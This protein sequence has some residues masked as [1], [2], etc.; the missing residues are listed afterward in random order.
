MAYAALAEQYQQQVMDK[1]PLSSLLPRATLDALPPGSDVSGL[2]ESCGLLSA[3]QLEIT[4]LDATE[5]LARIATKEFSSVEVVTAF[6]IRTA[7]AHQVTCCLTDFFIDEAIAAAQELDAYLAR[8]GKTR[9]PLHGLPISAKDQVELIGK[10]TSLGFT[11]LH[12]TAKPAT[13]N[14]QLAQILIDAGAVFFNHTTLPQSIMHLECNSFLWGR[15]LLPFN[16]SLSA[17]GSS[18]GEGAVLGMRGAPLGLG[19]DI[20]G[21][22]RS[23]AANNG[24]YGLRPTASRVPN[25]GVRTYVPGRDSILGI[26]GPLCHSA[27]DIELFMSVVLSS[28]AKPWRRD[29]SLLEMPWRVGRMGGWQEGGR[30]LRVGVMWHDGEV[31]PVRG[32]ERALKGA[33]EKLRKSGEVEVVDFE[34]WKTRE[35]WDLIRQLYFPDGGRRIHQLTD[36]SEVEEPLD[37]LTQWLLAEAGPPVRE[38]SIHELWEL[39]TRREAYRKGYQ[40]HWFSQAIDVL[41]CPV[42]PYPAPPH[43]E[44]KWWAYTSQ[45]NLVDYPAI[46]FPSGLTVDQELDAITPDDAAAYVPLSED[47]QLVHDGYHPKKYANAPISL[48]L[49][50]MRCHDEELMDA[51]VKI[52]GILKREE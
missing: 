21:S 34:P 23:P 9:G 35:G 12:S 38:L 42:A 51:L 40:A 2:P 1:L 20:G 39:N 52:E 17:G 6:G 31:R 44:A 4:G 18:G 11:S 46:A 27:R 13:S 32:V 28:D 19:T 33:V 43:G 49:V 24:L 37:P 48:Q 36:E 8:T 10:I 25:A 47:D 41:L 15:T 30:R 5:L 50:A 3:K 26:V 7:I 45:F 29:P 22:V 16:T 14:A